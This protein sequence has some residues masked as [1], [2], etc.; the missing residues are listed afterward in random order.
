MAKSGSIEVVVTPSKDD[1]HEICVKCKEM[2]EHLDQARELAAELSQMDISVS[3]SLPD[4]R[5]RT[6][7]SGS[8]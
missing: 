7:N 6:R 5:P 3:V 2:Q 4:Q 8:S 1:I